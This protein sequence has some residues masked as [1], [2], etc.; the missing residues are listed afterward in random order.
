MH[1]N[2]QLVKLIKSFY[3]K[4]HQKSTLEIREQRAWL[5]RTFLLT[6]RQADCVNAGFVLPTVAM[7][8]LVVI[9][10]TTAILFR[11]FKR[12]ENA[13]NVRVNQAVLSA[14]M[15]SV[16]RAKAK[17][18]YLLDK[19]QDDGISIPSDRTLND[20]LTG[21]DRGSDESR[22]TF[23]DET[24]L[25]V[26][27][28]IDGKSG[29]KENDATIENRE[30]ITTAWRYPVDTDN[31]GKYDS[32]TL[33]S[34]FFRSPTRGNDAKFDRART[35]LDARARPMGIGK[36]CGGAEG[37]SS[38]LATASGWYRFAGTL[39]KS[40]FVYSTTVPIDES[41]LKSASLNSKEYESYKGNKS[42]SAIE[43]QQDQERIPLSN[44]A[45][46]YEDDLEITP[47]AG[48]R[49]N[50]RIFTNSN[51]LTGK[52]YD[53][54][55]FYQVSDPDS[56]F[57][58]AQNSK[59]IVGGNVGFGRIT[60]GST[61]GAVN[62]DLFRPGNK[63]SQGK[64]DGSNKT[65]NNSSADI[66]FNSQAY[67]QRIN[68]LVEKQVKSSKDPSEVKNNI[69]S[70]LE[71]NPG[72][73][74]NQVR[75]EELESYFRKRTRKVT[76]KEVPFAQ[77]SGTAQLQDSGDLLRPQDSWIYPTNTN[78][79][80]SLI[81]KK[82]SATEPNTL[83]EEYREE[84]KLLGDRILV[85]NNLPALWFDKTIKDFVGSN[86]PQSV[87][88]PGKSV[89]KWDD[90]SDEKNKY[91]TRTTKIE[92]L[93]SLAGATDRD[94]FFEEKAT[95]K[96]KNVLDNVGGVRIVTGAGIYVDDV[97]Y[98][99]ADNS[100]LSEPQWDT[101]FVDPKSIDSKKI[102]ANSLKF[103]NKDPIIVWSDS[104]PMSGGSGQTGQG[105]LLM[106]ATAVYHYAKDYGQNQ[107]PIACVSSYYDPTNS[108]TAQN[109]SKVKGRWKNPDADPST[110]QGKSNN[111]IVY[112]FSS[113]SKYAAELE[114]QAR[115]VFPNGRF[116]NEPLR[117][118]LEKSTTKRTAA[119]YSAIDAAICALDI[120]KGQSSISST[121]P[122]GAIY[123]TSFLDARQVK[124]IETES[125]LADLGQDYTR[126][127]E[128]RQPLEVRVTVLDLDK[129]RKHKVSGSY[130]GGG[131][132][133][134]LIPNSGIIYATRDDALR[135]LSE[136]PDKDID[137]R[138]LISPTD[139]KLD[140]TRRPNGIM[141]INGSRLDRDIKFRQEEKGLILASNL[142][143]YIKGDF[144]LHAKGG[145]RNNQVEEFT[146][147]LLNDKNEI[148]WNK[149]YD[150]NKTLDYDFACRKGDKR[151]PK[152]TTG[153]S[154][155]AASVLADAVTVLSENFR[156]GFRNE[157]DY[158][159]RNNEGDLASVN[160][161]KQGF[162]DNNFLTSSNWFESSGK[163]IGY[164]KDFDT[165]ISE[166]QGSSYVNNFVTPIQRRVKFNE[167]L[168][169]IC[170]KI[171][172]S[173]CTSTD[174]TIDGGT[175]TA[176][177]EIGKKYDNN[178]THLAG[179]TVDLAFDS[180]TKDKDPELRRY[181]RRVAFARD[182]ATGD[183]IL[184][185]KGHP[186]PLGINDT[187]EIQAFPRNSVAS[188]TSWNVGQPRLK[189][190]AL[191]FRTDNGN[192]SKL[193]PKDTYYGH[194]KPLFY[195]TI[196]GKKLTGSS[197]EEQPI[198]VPVLQI[199]MPKDEWTKNN[200]ERNPGDKD[201]E[202][203]PSINNNKRGFAEDADTYWVQR[204]KTT[205]TNLILAGGDTP[206]RPSESNGGLENFV[207]YLEHWDNINH[208]ISG[209]L[210]Q[211]KRSV[212]A[213]APWQSLKDGSNPKSSFG[214]DYTQLYRTGTTGGRT[215]FYRAPSRQWG[216]D[217]GLL[218]QLPDL[219]TET[220]TLPPA[221]EPNE[222]FREVGRDDEWV[223][224]LLC[225]QIYNPSTK[226]TTG[227]A[228]IPNSQ[229]PQD[230]CKKY[231]RG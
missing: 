76:F 54:I 73:D 226:K 24:V 228:A 149:F 58:T 90:Y 148:N 125:K 208:S 179:T 4:N 182:V 222:F 117:K 14:A 175:T 81:L 91:R 152:C 220:F 217:V 198:L 227:K 108:I 92:Q 36:P 216:F 174:W 33:Y 68:S 178:K 190:N 225:A 82:L 63:P 180:N 118:A 93:V 29:F 206:A 184:D 12:A 102:K 32:F 139:Y 95:E 86:T 207:R 83:K 25:E 99:R 19:I 116:V 126:S 28:N 140:P 193:P 106:R 107:E 23:G 212:Y 151:L 218:S 145:N 130:S 191:W 168:M 200:N 75:R 187:G 60:G 77:N 53:D 146:D 7:V 169:E 27:Y 39:K 46:V 172:V 9:L 66:A 223:K 192:G 156:F 67:A 114:R 185:D 119:D 224:T 98:Q 31:N 171:P 111:G 105:D 159:L 104:M 167:Y 13:S 26:S 16:G 205:T 150:R 80:L 109:N 43:F 132:Q 100:F 42:F 22:Y 121:I 59:I 213:T 176:T 141:L 157:G 120:L 6:R 71:D 85:G 11:S 161:Q 133:E 78:T 115:M 48:L 18:K 10:L 103:K 170:P 74:K 51:L 101:N 166:I 230:F 203:L 155:R 229:R 219:F 124:S 35:P 209:S 177:S 131:K 69:D 136:S 173:S 183:L 158:D 41:Y 165:S 134:Y 162:L 50:G 88:Y 215:P 194:G 138:K 221:T 195:Q 5:L 1:P 49:L 181:A 123:E 164:P 129:M 231:T 143:A 113:R 97:T 3:Q 144:N 89:T 202:N 87:D 214:S 188:Q 137:Q 55:R 127:L 110:A 210:I 163:R 45:V 57:Y 44:N 47:G 204:P 199:H 20:F 84:E 72:L 52:S 30:T 122:H 56:C 37:T 142:P 65:A 21:E 38:S 96:P 160:Y 94:G 201:R 40:F 64:I 70:R 128:Q 62:V 79:K 197:S 17:I 8:T 211:Y 135:D 15:P 186:V 153:D 189:T 154:W 34:I 196:D 61:K 2:H 147:R 112:N